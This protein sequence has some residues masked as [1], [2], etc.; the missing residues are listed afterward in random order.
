[1]DTTA[2]RTNSRPGLALALLLVVAV[3]GAAIRFLPY[4]LGEQGNANFWA[5]NVTP[6]LAMMIFG[7]AQFRRVELG[8]LC[9]LS[10]LLAT[11]LALRLAGNDPSSGWSRLPF[12]ALFASLGLLGLV[13]KEKRTWPRLL[14]VCVAGPVGFFLISNFGVWLFADVLYGAPIY[15][16]NLKGLLECYWNALPFLRNDLIGTTLF[17]GGLFGSYAW[18]ARRV[19]AM[20][21][22]D[23][24]LVG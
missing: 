1:M 9:P 12:Y 6:V 8:L 14:G 4:S 17:L 13:V 20:R 5:W 11:D 2:T 23:P 7:V 19:P 24:A 15:P 18:L 16:K 22:A 21:E 10:M 3:I